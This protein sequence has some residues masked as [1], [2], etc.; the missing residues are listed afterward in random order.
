MTDKN[1]DFDH[2]AEAARMFSLIGNPVAEIRAIPR[3]DRDLAV[4]LFRDDRDFGDAA[5]GLSALHG[6]ERAFRRGLHDCESA[7]R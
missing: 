7:R 6:Q 5:V 4:G 3:D 2:E 1:G